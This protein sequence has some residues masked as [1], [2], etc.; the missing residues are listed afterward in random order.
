MLNP[1][2]GCRHR[3]HVTGIAESPELLGIVPA[4]EVG[5]VLEEILKGLHVGV[6]NVG[7]SA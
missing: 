3:A 2:A 7:V 5:E 4:E 6:L 1:A